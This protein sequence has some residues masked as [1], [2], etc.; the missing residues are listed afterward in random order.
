MKGTNGLFIAA[1]DADS[2]GKEGA[3]YVWK[4]DEIKDILGEETELL[5]NCLKLNPFEHSNEFVISL[6]TDL[7]YLNKDANHELIEINN[8]LV[9]LLQKRSFRIPPIKDNKQILAWNALM[10]TAYCHVFINTGIQSYC[11]NALKGIRAIT[12]LYNIEA[13]TFLFARTLTNNKQEGTAFLE[14]Y[15]YLLEAFISCYQISFDRYY[16]TC[17]ENL[18]KHLNKQFKHDHYLYSLA[19]IEQSGSLEAIFDT[20]DSAIPNPNSC[21]C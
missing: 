10:I 9:K 21:Y 19:S 6:Q 14:D 17:A 12:D 7:F 8:L 15:A 2:E 3:Y 16:I 20:V 1:I 11:Q 4:L 5:L 18:I 13:G